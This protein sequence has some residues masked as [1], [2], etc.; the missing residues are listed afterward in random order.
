MMKFLCKIGIHKWQFLGH[1]GYGLD[2]SLKR[3]KRCGIGHADYCY[4]QAWCR[5]SSEEMERLLHLKRGEQ[6]QI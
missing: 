3:C 5:Y 1:C 4:G 2:T 6:T